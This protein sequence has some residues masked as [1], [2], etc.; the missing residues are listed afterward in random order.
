MSHPSAFPVSLKKT[1]YNWWVCFIKQIVW[2]QFPYYIIAHPS[3]SKISET[4]SMSYVDISTNCWQVRKCAQALVL[5]LNT[6]V[7]GR[8][9]LLSGRVKSFFWVPLLF[10]T[11]FPLLQ[12][13]HH[14]FLKMPFWLQNLFLCSILSQPFP[15][16]YSTNPYPFILPASFCLFAR[17]DE[18]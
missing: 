1:Q 12:R 18:F 14:Q 17:S 7:N 10:N 16:Q 2:N 13:C 9:F 8:I 11:Y 4:L 3:L 15:P 6:A 5:L